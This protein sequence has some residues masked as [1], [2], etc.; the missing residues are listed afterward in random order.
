[1]NGIGILREGP[2]K[3]NLPTEETLA[4]V[5]DAAGLGFFKRTL[6]LD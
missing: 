1:M 4:M 3:A 6:E 5:K 2:R